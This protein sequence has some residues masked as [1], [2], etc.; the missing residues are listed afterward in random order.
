MV[1]ENFM[2]SLFPNIS[3]ANNP[4]LGSLLL[5]FLENHLQLSL[6]P[7]E[8]NIPNVTEAPEFTAISDLVQEKR[9]LT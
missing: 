3:K 4:T 5:L 9:I 8:G 1:L 2:Y 7:L 6:W